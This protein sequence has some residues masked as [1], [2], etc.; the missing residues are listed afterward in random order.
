LRDRTDAPNLRRRSRGLG[1]LPRGRPLGE[2]GTATG[3]ASPRLPT[4]PRPPPSGRPAG[5]GSSGPPNGSDR[6]PAVSCCRRSGAGGGTR[7]PPARDPR[8]V[9]GD[10]GKPTGGKVHRRERA[11]QQT[12]PTCSQRRARACW[13]QLDG[14]PHR[15][16]ASSPLRRTQPTH[17][18]SRPG[19]IDRSNRSLGAASR[20]ASWHQSPPIDCFA[21]ACYAVRIQGEAPMT[22]HHS[23]GAQ[24]GQVAVLFAFAALAVIAIVGLALDAGQAFVDQ[25]SLQAGTDAAAQSGASMLQA[26]F[27]ACLSGGASPM[28][29]DDQQILNE[30]TSL[31][32][33]A[34]TAQGKSAPGSVTPVFVSYPTGTLIVDQP[35]PNNS[36]FSFL[37]PGASS[38]TLF[39]TA[40]AWTG[41]AGVATGASD[42]H[43]T[44]ILQVVGIKSATEAARSTALFGSA[45]GGGAPFA[46]WDAYCYGS[47]SDT[48]LVV[49]DPVVLLDSK[50]W[51][52]TCG[53]GS[54]ASFKGYID[55]TSPLS[56]PMS[57]GSCIQTG[58]G[59]GIKTPPTPGVG[60]TVLVP[61]ISSF[62]KGTCPGSPSGSSGPYELTYAG[63]IAVRIT[64]SSHTSIDG[65]VTSTSPITAGITICPAGD[66]ACAPATSATPTGV[67]LYK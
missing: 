3:P 27:H 19:G 6:N 14:S 46:A 60:D 42:T 32:A 21:G 40:G 35:I 11:A 64:S 1:H 28:P 54:P 10:N 30:V 56:L 26:D 58:V 20:P 39:C 33:S 23:R 63:L 57:V 17:P 55:P 22:R 7:N 8:S 34:Q 67:E 47:S 51:K 36:T 66:S 13:G 15:G 62:S 24:D 12:L 61:I 9:I 48:P 37:P 29:Y 50:W 49:N 52:Y 45:G 16:P 41:P 31:V 25:R 38:P 2:A 4:P 65:V 44:L 43:P 5:S 53:F 18:G 59:V